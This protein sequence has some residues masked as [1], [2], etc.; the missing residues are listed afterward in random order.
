MFVH[1]RKISMVWFETR[2]YLCLSKVSIR[3]VYI[4]FKDTTEYGS[5]YEGKSQVPIHN[6]K[7]YMKKTLKMSDGPLSQSEESPKMGELR[8]SL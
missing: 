3:L 7:T 2:N 1:S 8:P 5:I 6:K 4:F